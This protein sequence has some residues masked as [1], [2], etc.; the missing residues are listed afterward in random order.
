MYLHLLV[1]MLTIG[2]SPDLAARSRSLRG[3]RVMWPLLLL[4]GWTLLA[5]AHA[6][7]F[8]DMP[9][10]LFHT[11]RVV[12]VLT[13]AMMLWRIEALHALRG[14]L[15]GALFAC[16]LVAANRIWGL[17]DWAV[18]SSL[19]APRNNF[20]SAN[21]IALAIAAGI[22]FCLVFRAGARPGERW[23]AFAASLAVGLT[24]VLH[25]VSRNAHVLLALVT[26]T[27]VIYR[28]RSLRAVTAGL[29]TVLVLTLSA[30]AFSPTIQSRFA[31][32]SSN[33]HAVEAESRY[34]SSIG[35]R[36]RMYQEA[37]SEM[38]RHPLLGA[39][40][41]SWL[42]HWKS[43]WA[44]LD[45]QL[46]LEESTRFAEINNPHNDFLLA[47]METGVPGLLI[48]V[49]LFAQLAATGWHHR[50]TMGGVSVMVSVALAATA[51]VNAPLR[52]AAFGT[53]LLW[54]LGASLAAQRKVLRA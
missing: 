16:I 11:F 37:Y 17:P 18:W 29:V 34:N 54:L 41:G 4:L 22:F 1:M 35:V 38:V 2:L 7:A 43:I 31:E 48:L 15:F 21:M 32:V 5:A 51:M 20:S 6:G 50:S 9:T 19:I 45:Q 24:V 33:M 3:N 49:W 30:W 27:V 13:L 42:P 47:G 12:L 39:G 8:P 14:F 25:A 36:W 46:P 10:R 44:S 52:D 40:V 26:M 23:F 28:F 53:T